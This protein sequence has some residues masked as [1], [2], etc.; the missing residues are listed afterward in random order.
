MI[1]ALTL[2]LRLRRGGPFS[3]G[4]SRGEVHPDDLIFRAAEPLVVGQ[5]VSTHAG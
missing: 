3:P 2:C 5:Q 1:G 4:R